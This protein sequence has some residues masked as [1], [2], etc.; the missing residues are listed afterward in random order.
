MYEKYSGLP[1]TTK[2]APQTPQR[3]TERTPL[4]GVRS[5]GNNRD[6][7]YYYTPNRGGSSA[8]RRNGAK[9]VQVRKRR[10]VLSLMTAV[11]LGL[12]VIAVVVLAR[13]C[14]DPAVVDAETGRFR[15]EVYING[16][17]LSG[18]SV[19]DVRSQLESNEAYALN[20][21]SITLSG[22]DF[23]ASVSGADMNASSNLEEL[24]QAALAG[25][26]NQVYYTT[27][28]IDRDALVERINEINESMT[29]PP[30]DASFTVK[31]SDSGK[32]TFEYSEG[33][34]GYGIDVASTVD[35]VQQV[36]ASGQLQAV[37]Q[38][39][40]TTV[41][42]T[43]TIADIQAHTAL[44]GSF[45]TT[46][47]FKG[48]AEDTEEQRNTLI[49]N[50]AF[51]IEKS[52][53]LI[54]NQTI[55]PGKTWSFND[56]VGDRVEKNGWKQ[57]YGIFGGNIYTLQYG[58][59]VCQV[60]TTLYNALLDAYPY[61]TFSR[62]EH[63][64]PSSYVEKG[65]DATVDTGHIDFK[66]TNKS[67]YPVY[68]YAY[69]SKN[70]MASGRKRDLTVLVYGEAL[71]EGTEYKTRTNVVEEIPPGED[72]ILETSSLFIG[73]EEVVVNARNGYVVDVYVDRYLNGELQESIFLYTDR[74]DGNPLKVRIGT[75]ATPTPEPSPTPTPSPTVNP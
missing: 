9:R 67:E 10:L 58:G 3:N 22:E 45:T 1:D 12:I 23:S 29:T 51:N 21:I 2:P 41:A 26:S 34:P 32:P 54:N 36:I 17:N 43:K 31:L 5:E 18:K 68:I 53:A 27:I 38:P 14:S 39:V 20:N 50:R 24:I 60:S 69:V 25:G 57:A 15:N 37:L 19:S 6:M 73:E 44:I 33:T 49:P 75:K 30:A 7:E 35:E 66:F 72:I 70:S 47:D 16:M 63:S 56:T 40:L 4:D 65:L 64:I 11:F 48:T 8:A 46:Y 55:D 42:P 71:P 74:Y 61:F 28:T 13:S 62:Q 59:G 52:A